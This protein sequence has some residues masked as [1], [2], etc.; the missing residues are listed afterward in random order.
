MR[1]ALEE[2]DRSGPRGA[3]SSAAS[4]PREAGADD[5]DV[6]GARSR[7]ARRSRAQATRGRHGLPQVHLAAAARARAGRQAAQRRSAR[8]PRG[9]RRRGRGRAASA[10]VERGLE[11]CRGRARRNRRCSASASIAPLPARVGMSETADAPQSKAKS[12][13]RSAQSSASASGE[14]AGR[15]AGRRA[16]RCPRR[17]GSRRPRRK[18][19]SV[20]RLLSRASTSG[21]TVSSPIAT[22]SRAGRGGR[23]ES[24]AALARR[25]PDATRR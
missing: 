21:C 11:R 18:S 9:R 25:A 3:Q 20:M 19:S 6:E 22:S 13:E 15:R 2:H 8:G 5:R 12:T 17:A 1:S 4:E 23:A 24:Q 7:E 16:A 14:T 10:E